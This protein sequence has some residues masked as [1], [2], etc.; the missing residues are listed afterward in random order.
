MAENDCCLKTDR[1]FGE[2]KNVLGEQNVANQKIGK[3]DQQ[4]QVIFTLAKDHSFIGQ[5]RK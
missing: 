2:Q 1:D 5:R 4:Q 3:S